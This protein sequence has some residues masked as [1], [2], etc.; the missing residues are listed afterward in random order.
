[1]EIIELLKNLCTGN[2]LTEND[3][4]DFAYNYLS[5][6]TNSVKKDESGNILA[7]INKDAD[8]TIM[9]DAHI[10]KIGFVVTGITDD[11]FLK[12]SAM[13]GIDNRVLSAQ[14]VTV[15]SK[16][17]LS[18]VIQTLPPHLVKDEEKPI[19]EDKIYID[20]GLNG[21]LA[22]DTVSLGDK[23]YFRNNLSEM[24]NSLV[25]SAY[26]D[27]KAGVVALLS[28]AE[29][30]ANST[31]CPCNLVILLSNGE[32][33]GC[34]GARTGAFKITPDEGVAVDV[35]FGDDKFTEEHKC[36]KLNDGAMIGISPTLNKKITDKL[37]KIAKD[38]NIKNQR[39]VMGG[40]TGTNADVISV[41]K[42]G[43]P[44]GLLSIPLRYMHTPVEVV[45][46]KDV[47]SVSDILYNY[48]MSGGI[49]NA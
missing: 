13:G 24:Q 40:A 18:G 47:E 26:L 1:M 42:D 12:V 6:F 45:S 36:G 34:R 30:I 33:L 8:Y 23:V 31:D 4:I 2:G 14:P 16:E 19:E 43:I 22:K 38:K 3:E 27:D 11:G 15:F 28:V 32:E 9:L 17:A 39:E 5:T 20:V 25:T 46:A 7:L 21:A 10:D 48:V 35:S 49:M 44:T 37:L 41:T 29:K